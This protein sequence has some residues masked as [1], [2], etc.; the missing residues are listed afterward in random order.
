LLGKAAFEENQGSM[1]EAFSNRP[2]TVA[3]YLT[4]LRRRKWLVLVPPVVAALV[5]FFVASSQHPLYQAKSSILVNTQ[6]VVSAI[7]NISN[8]A[9]GD[10]DRF[11][12]TQASIARSPD[13]ANRIVAAAG[14]PGLT[15]GR[16]LSESYVDPSSSSDILY[17]GVTD[18]SAPV[19]ARLA[20]TYADEF[21]HY[22]TELDTAHINNALSVLKTRIDSLRASGA[23]AS[24]AYASLVQTQGDLE[25]IGKL[26]A[27]N[28]SVLTRGSAGKISPRPQRDALI[29]LAFGL[30]LGLALAFLADAL[31]RHVRT[32][33]ELESALQLP[34]LGRL[35]KPSREL[36][37]T[38]D[39]VMLKEPASA[40][41]E[42]FRK[43]RT[44]FEFINPA[45]AAK[46]IMVTSAVEQ[47]GKSTT[48]ANLAIALAR[49]DRRVVLVD[50][51]LRRPFLNRLFHMSGRPGITDVAMKHVELKDALR[52]I[53][54]QP[55]LGAAS[56][57]GKRA[58][59][60]TNGRSSLQ[61]LLHLLPA[62][63][64]AMP[65][66]D[67]LR[68]PRLL[69]VLDQLADRFDLVLIDAPPLLAF[70]DAMIL[71]R[72]VDGIFAITRLNT[73][74]RPILHEFAR[75]LQNCQANL[76]G[77]VLTGV[78]HTESY[79]YMYEAYAYEARERT[80]SREPV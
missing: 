59:G 51:D 16:V 66:G 39:L 61:G 72:H 52:P 54:L 27:D 29:G 64:I 62:G 75:Q 10:P 76:L 36:Q 2:T 34:L 37:K 58:T 18:R 60:P 11:L 77:F 50:L 19:A 4:I 25:T 47:E 73:V 55:S 49:S 24:P 13:L 80:S 56:T 28:T 71:S 78:E 6:S 70:D 68:D 14:I 31:D 44:S 69:D 23:T 48:I 3:E 7:A 22:K 79:R 67:L 35:P 12:T 45:G 17:V 74:Q 20:N 32:E 53:P 15:A 8:P 33:E 65:A 41:A 40:D 9:A 38:T 57:N 46:T 42:A 30:V 21:T 43:L 26:L 63:T 5:A 1:T